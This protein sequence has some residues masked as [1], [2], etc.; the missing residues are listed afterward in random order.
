MFITRQSYVEYLQTFHIQPNRAKLPS[1]TL[2][3]LLCYIVFNLSNLFIIFKGK[4]VSTHLRDCPELL[5]VMLHSIVVN[6]TVL[7]RNKSV[8]EKKIALNKRLDQFDGTALN[9]LEKN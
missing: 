6:G 5:C 9:N 1:F 7:N 3:S 8:F 4:F 2:Y